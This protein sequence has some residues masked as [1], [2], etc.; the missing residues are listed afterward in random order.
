MNIRTMVHVTVAVQRH[1]FCGLAYFSVQ[2]V[3]T[4]VTER[5]LEEVVLGTVFQERTVHRV[6]SNLKTQSTIHVCVVTTAREATDNMLRQR[7][8][9]SVITPVHR[10]QLLSDTAPAELHRLLLSEGTCLLSWKRKSR[11]SSVQ[12]SSKIIK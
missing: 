5:C 3:Y 7:L 4:E 11:S 9:A 10:S 1:K 2:H 12:M 8:P 6:G